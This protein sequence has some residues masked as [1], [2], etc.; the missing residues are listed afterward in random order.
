MKAWAKWSPWSPNQIEGLKVEYSGTPSGVGSAQSWT[1]QRGDGKLWIVESVPNQRV[2]YRMEFAGFPEMASSIE[3]AAPTKNP[4]DGAQT[5][6]VFSQ[7]NNRLETEKQRREFTK[8]S[9]TGAFWFC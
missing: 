6:V 3:L 9:V 5:K 4:A 7:K 1:D 8:G 2:G